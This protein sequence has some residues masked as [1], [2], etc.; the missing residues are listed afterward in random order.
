MAGSLRKISVRTLYSMRKAATTV[1]KS[2]GR[3]RTLPTE[4]DMAEKSPPAA[5]D[6]NRKVQVH[7]NK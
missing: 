2:K 5:K 6:V 7:V 1:L 4:M 3:Y